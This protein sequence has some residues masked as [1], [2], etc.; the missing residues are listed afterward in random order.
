[1]ISRVSTI[2]KVFKLS[3]DHVGYKENILNIEQ[4]V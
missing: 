3:K 4:D 2:I 1:M